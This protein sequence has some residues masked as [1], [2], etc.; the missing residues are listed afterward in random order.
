M[1]NVGTGAAGRT[2][3][4]T[5]NTSSP[6]F[7]AIGTLSGLTQHGLLIGQNAGSFTA[8]S[9]GTLGQIMQSQGAADPNWT[10]AT[11]PGSAVQG[12]LMYASA[13]NVWSSLAKDTN[14]TRYLSNTGTSNAPAWAQVNL[15]N[16]VTGNL[17]VGNLNSGTSASSSTFWRGD[18]TWAVPVGAGFT[19]INTQ[20]FTSSGTYTPTANMK[21]CMIEC[22]GGGGGGGG[23]S[24]CSAAQSSVG[25]G[26]GGGGYARVAASAA[27]IGASQTVTVGAGGT[28]GA[29]G[30]GNGGTGGTT[31]LGSLC[32]ATGGNPGA[33]SA[34]T[35]AVLFVVGGGASGLGS[36]GTVLGGSTPGSFG[37]SSS[38]SG[39][40]ASG[41]GGGA[42]YGRGANSVV[43]LGAGAGGAGAG[44][45][46]GGSGGA[47]A[48]SN[49]QQTG[50]AGATGAVIIT[51][52]I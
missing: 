40:V 4:G 2:L 39:Y 17:P 1:A 15:A 42:I 52:Y 20:I 10:T 5:G 16:G 34:A 7:A 19:T 49:T 46:G 50:G 51:E 29:V 12:D 44:Y 22:I 28:A 21:Y 25:G 3:I 38:T 8:T 9:A 36:T 33:G 6:T 26:G 14:A 30:G 45:G 37:V 47:T 31:S 35:S 48:P 32:S 24:T 27:T 13:T 11:Y 43:G 18:G 23:T 41:A